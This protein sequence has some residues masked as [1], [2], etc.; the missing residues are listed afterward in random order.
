MKRFQF[1]RI[2]IIFLGMLLLS[3]TITSCSK[4]EDV[5]LTNALPEDQVQTETISGIFPL[6]VHVPGVYVT[7]AADKVG[8]CEEKSGNTCMIIRCNNKSGNSNPTC[9]VLLPKEN[10]FI[11]AIEKTADLVEI[12]YD[13]TTLTQNDLTNVFVKNSDGTA[14]IKGIAT[15]ENSKYL[16]NLKLR[17]N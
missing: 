1:G 15:K 6:E 10:S 11:N 7:E 8:G 14:S 16:F 4:K 9:M 12:N 5:G 2:K 17:F 3:L 13:P